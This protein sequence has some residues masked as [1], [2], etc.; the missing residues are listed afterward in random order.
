MKLPGWERNKWIFLLLA[1][2][3]ALLLLLGAVLGERDGD[4][5]GYAGYLE[6]RA[7]SLCLSIDG[8]EDAEVFLTLDEMP[9]AVEAGV[10]GQET[11]RAGVPTV[12]GVAVVCTGGDLPRI[13][14]AVT[15]L[16][17]AA[18]GVPTSRIRVKGK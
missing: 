1:A 9:Q 12:R 18:L 5:S 2:M 7:R 14:S 6:G 10:F 15:E 3:G 16:L 4:A 13:R 11:K 8:V 17:S